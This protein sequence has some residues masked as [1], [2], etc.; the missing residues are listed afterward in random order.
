MALATA[1]FGMM[2]VLAM[3]GRVLPQLPAW[4]FGVLIANVAIGAVCYIVESR[5][6]RAKWQQWR[7]FMEDKTEWDVLLGRHVPDLRGQPVRER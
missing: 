3:R 2:A 4:A 6:N 1:T 7:S 5:V